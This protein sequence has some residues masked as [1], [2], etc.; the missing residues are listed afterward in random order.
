[1][2]EF[3][4]GLRATVLSDSV[5]TVSSAEHSSTAPLARMK[6]VALFA[7]YDTETEVKP[8]VVTLLRGLR[9]ACDEIV[10]GSTAGLSEGELERV[11]PL[12]SRTFVRENVGYDF[13]VWR[14]ALSAVDL[15]EVDELVLANSSVFGPICPLAPIF[16]QMAEHDCDFW[17]MT[18]SFEIRWHVQSYFLVFKRRA[19]RAPAFLQFFDAVL[20]YRDKEQVIRSYELGLTQFLRE[21][22]LK[23]GA[24]VPLGS[25]LSSPLRRARLC[26]RRRNATLYY[27]LQ[28]IAAGMPF[29]KMQ[30]LRDNPAGVS[31][32]EVLRAMGAAGYDVSQVRFDRRATPP[33]SLVGAVLDSFN[34]ERVESE[35][36]KI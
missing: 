9:E 7:H 11:R 24:F 26:A 28:L 6:R 1:L 13:A 32:A 4:K 16:E 19:L 5:P 15:S 20:P 3:S 14:H 21:H 33:K 17:G 27:P 12:C 29:V 2:Q 18:D 23:P 31:V 34:A 25:W 35:R 10:F 36:P 8:Y 30:L 22:G